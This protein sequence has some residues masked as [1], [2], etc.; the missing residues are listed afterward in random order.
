MEPVSPSE[1]PRP[2]RARNFSDQLTLWIGILG[3]LITII[4]TVWNARTKNK[5]DEG[6]SVF[7]ACPRPDRR[8]P[9]GHRST[10]PGPWA[11]TPFGPNTTCD[12]ISGQMEPGAK[13]GQGE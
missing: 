10:V 2:A 9:G 4:L 7:S 1:S 11:E 8:W 5:I 12:R 6:V 13:P 3:S